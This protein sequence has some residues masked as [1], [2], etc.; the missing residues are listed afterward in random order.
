MM[1]SLNNFLP[2]YQVINNK[3]QKAPNNNGNQPP[4][5]ILRAFAAKNAKS[6]VM[7]MLIMIVTNT[8]FH[9]HTLRMTTAAKNVVMTMVVVTAIP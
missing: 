2:V 8:E 4:S 1:R 7:N 6:T 5:A 3:K 9:F